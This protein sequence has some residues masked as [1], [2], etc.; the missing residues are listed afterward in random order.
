MGHLLWS[1]YPLVPLVSRFTIMGDLPSIIQKKKISFVWLRFL[2]Y[3]QNRSFGVCWLP[4]VSWELCSPELSFPGAAV[5]LLELNPIEM[6]PGLPTED[7]LN[8]FFILNDHRNGLIKIWECFSVKN[9]TAHTFKLRI[10]SDQKDEHPLFEGVLSFSRLRI[11]NR[12]IM[13]I[14]CPNSL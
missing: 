5:S 3:T 12:P 10:Q 8:L 4:P 11:T 7:T 2:L 13:I 1:R 14:L 9:L 6:P